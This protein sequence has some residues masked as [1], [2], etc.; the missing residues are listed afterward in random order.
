M[1]SS[2]VRRCRSG[3][4][5]GGGGGGRVVYGEAGEGEVGGESKAG[6]AAI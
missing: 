2:G 5:E 6:R 4:D 1:G 3:R